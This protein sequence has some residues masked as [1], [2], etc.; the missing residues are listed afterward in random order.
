MSEVHV[1]ELDEG[2]HV[3]S[4]S[5]S[6]RSHQ[7]AAAAQPVPSRRPPSTSVGQCACSTMRAQPTRI[8]IAMARICR[9]SRAAGAGARGSGGRAAITAKAAAA[10]VWPLGKPSENPLGRG[11]ADEELEDMLERARGEKGAHP[12][13]PVASRRARKAPRSRG[14]RGAGPSRCRPDSPTRRRCGA[15]SCLR[16]G[17]LCAHRGRPGGCPPHRRRGP[18]PGTRRG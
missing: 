5:V 12:E 1:L 18:G 17:A 7:A 9:E 10:V 11:T 2:A 13:P 15:A 4:P 16:S 3:N 8:I 6:R 14:S